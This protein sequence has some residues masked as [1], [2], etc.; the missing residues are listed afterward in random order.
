LAEL[1]S[2]PAATYPEGSDMWENVLIT[3][4]LV[5]SVVLVIA[6]AAAILWLADGHGLVGAVTRK[7]LG[8]VVISVGLCLLAVPIFI[9]FTG[10]SSEGVSLI[11]GSIV[12]I[13]IIGFGWMW[14]TGGSPGIE[15]VGISLEC[16][17]VKASVAKA[18]ATLPW[19]REQVEKKTDSA[20]VKFP[21]ITNSGNAEHIWGYVHS[22]RDGCFNVS[23]ANFPYDEEED[24]EGRRNVA[25]EAVEDWQIM[26]PDGRIEGAYSLLALFAHWEKQGKRLTK[27][28]RQQKA[29]LI[30]H[31][32]A[33]ERL[34][35]Q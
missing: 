18:Q 28:M 10:A 7:L 15:D 31:N 19:F 27:T 11:G 9:L 25:L 5:I 23:L 2:K 26:Y 33:L 6:F 21:L 14:L 13:V 4:F 20:F 17:E 8:L 32:A 29:Q 16:E 22:F 12:A 1:H 34:D 3:V 30:G 35:G 24:P